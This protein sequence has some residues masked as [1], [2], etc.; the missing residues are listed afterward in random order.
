[1]NQKEYWDG[2][3][4]NKKF[5]TPFQI[6]LF[7]EHVSPKMRV[8]DVGCGYGRTMQEL[9]E[10][11]YSNLTGVDFSQ[12]MIDQ[13]KA[14]Y[15]HLDMMRMQGETLPFEDKSFD[16]VV[17]L[18]VLTC[19]VLDQEQ[20]RLIG[21][22]ERVLNDGGVVFVNDFLINSDKRNTDRYE[23]FAKVH[24]KY[25]VFELPEGAFLRHHSVEYVKKLLHNFTET[26]FETVVYTTMNKHKSNGFYYVG[27]KKME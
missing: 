9:R 12:G 15:P 23:K 17:L 8:L 5:S 2:V 24:G 20:A 11:G 19:I 13:G 22:I 1:M 21:E 6:E 14:L 3:S 4:K 26:A 27:R 18:A 16:A 10:A 25:G 7:R